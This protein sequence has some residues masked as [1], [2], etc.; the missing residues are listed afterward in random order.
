MRLN[1]PQTTTVTTEQEIVAAA[2]V[3][4]DSVV[5]VPGSAPAFAASCLMLLAT[6]AALL[7]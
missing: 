4:P 2:I 7:L 6:L 3:A 5:D 1:Q